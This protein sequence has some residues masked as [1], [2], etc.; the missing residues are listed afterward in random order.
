MQASIEP[1][2]VRH[3]LQSRTQS[4]KDLPQ[5]SI[6]IPHTRVGSAGTCSDCIV[7]VYGIMNTLMRSEGGHSRCWGEEEEEGAGG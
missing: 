7:K 2:Y 4:K 3:P 5:S 6:C 1:A